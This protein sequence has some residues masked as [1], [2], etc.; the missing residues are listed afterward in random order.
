MMQCVVSDWCLESCHNNGPQGLQD[1]PAGG[2]FSSSLP[3][4][5]QEGGVVFIDADFEPMERERGDVASNSKPWNWYVDE[6]LD[7]PHAM[8]VVH[9]TSTTLFASDR[10]RLVREG[11]ATPDGPVERP[12]IHHPGAVAVI[13]QPEPGTLLLVRQYRYAIRRETLEIPAGTRVVGE[14]AAVTAAR[15]LREEAGYEAAVWEALGSFLP[16][17]GVSDEELHLFRARVLTDVPPAPEHGELVAREV[18][19]LADLPRLARAGLLCDAK[20]I[21]AAQMLGIRLIP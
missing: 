11:F 17:V 8:P 4:F 5:G 19:A 14:P 15:E 16:A 7:A 18:V 3:G 13:A 6:G 2:T 1:S 21:I 20:T 12:V 10:F 9:T